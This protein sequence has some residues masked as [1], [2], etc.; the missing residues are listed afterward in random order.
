MKNIIT[1]AVILVLVIGVVV[2]LYTVASHEPTPRESLLLGFLLFTCSAFLTWLCTHLYSQRTM[3]QAIDAVRKEYE[4]N[5]RTYA[6]QAAEKVLN[7]SSQLD[8]LAATLELA[9]KQISVSDSH[10]DG[11]TSILLLRNQIHNT[12]FVL[13]TLRAAN[14][15]SLSDWRGVIGEEIQKQ[16]GLEQQID[17]MREKLESLQTLQYQL[18]GTM[19]TETQMEMM[20][21]RIQE[22][23]QELEQKIGQLPFVSWRRQK[24]RR[25]RKVGVVCIACDSSTEIMIKTKPGSRRYW[26]C[27]SCKTFHDI[28]TQEGDDYDFNLAETEVVEVECVLCHSKHQL[29]LPLYPGVTLRTECPEC[30]LSFDVARSKEGVKCCANPKKNLPEKF[31]SKIRVLL[32][33]RSNWEQGIHKRIAEKL[34]VSN[35]IVTQAITILIERGEVEAAPE[36]ILDHSSVDDTPSSEPSTF[37]DM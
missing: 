3:A 21:D 31:I 23:Q 16:H 34:G 37:K 8:R 24:I 19:N 1:V 6:K 12:I 28:V 29:S 2:S 5:L 7:L 27:P 4:G 20:E 13:E 15:N 30:D 11:T 26:R 25:R 9:L 17:D 22:V 10:A 36:G 18:E 35:G 14:D 33:P 32:P